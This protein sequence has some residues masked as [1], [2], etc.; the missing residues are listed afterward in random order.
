MLADLYEFAGSA[1][2]VTADDGK[3]RKKQTFILPPRYD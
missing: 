2:L 3:G 1:D